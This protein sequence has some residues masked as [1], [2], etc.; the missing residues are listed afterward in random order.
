MTRVCPTRRGAPRA[1]TDASSTSPC[2]HLATKPARCQ[3]QVKG[4]S[5]TVFAGSIPE[6]YDTLLVQLIFEPYAEDLAHRVAA[7]KPTRVLETAIDTVA[8]RSRAASPL[9]PAMAYCQGT[10]L[11]NEI[12]SR[13]AAHGTSLAEVT[14]VA[15]KAIAERFGNGAVDGKI[16]ARVVKG[17]E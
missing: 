1:L 8:A 11:R 17:L 15:A 10:P 2:A 16:Q 12:E 5:D 9:I 13:C 4:N 3:A 7:S 6:I 14:A